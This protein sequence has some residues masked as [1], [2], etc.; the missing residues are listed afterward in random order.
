MVDTRI[1]NNMNISFGSLTCESASTVVH[2]DYRD[3]LML[4]VDSLSTIWQHS[5]QMS[6]V[7]VVSCNTKC[8]TR[9]MLG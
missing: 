8:M 9:E 3:R 4:E 2:S 6:V 7:S 1:R 5:A